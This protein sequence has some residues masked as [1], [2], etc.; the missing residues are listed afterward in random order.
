MDPATKQVISAVGEIGSYGLLGALVV[1]LGWA[2]YKKDRALYDQSEAFRA[3]IITIQREVIM[4]VNKM[5]DLVE[6]IEKREQ[7]RERESAR[8]PTR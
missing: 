1:I 3:Q 7:E 5:S 8:R 6:F 4:A 2:Y